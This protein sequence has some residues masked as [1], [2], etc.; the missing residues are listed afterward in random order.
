MHGNIL[1]WCSDAYEKY[2][3]GTSTDPVVNLGIRQVLRGGSCISN[4]EEVSST[5][6]SSDQADYHGMFGGFRFT[7]KRIDEIRVKK[8]VGHDGSLWSPPETDVV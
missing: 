4:A 6:R 8:I 2:K 1:E 5:H 3:K 7:K